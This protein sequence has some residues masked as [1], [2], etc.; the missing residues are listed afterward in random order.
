MS[1]KYYLPS[2]VTPYLRRILAEYKRDGKSKLVEIVSSS[3]IY[4]N[5]SIS[6]TNWDGGQDGHGVTLFLP[7]SVLHSIPIRSQKQYTDKLLEDLRT[8]AEQ[9]SGEYFSKVS[10]EAVDETDIHCQQAVHLTE[11]P[12]IDPDALTIWDKGC[13][14]L[15]ISHRDTHKAQAR[16]LAD[17]LQSYGI[18]A[19]VAHETIG[20][21]EKWQKVILDGLDTMEIMLAFITDD[22]QDSVWT[23][24][25]IGYALARN[26]PIL[27]LKLGTKDPAGFISDTQALKGKLDK[28]QGA[29]PEIY[30][31]LAEKLGNQSRLQAGL[32]DAFVHSP[33]FNAT[34][35]RFDR[36]KAHVTKLTDDELNKIIAAYETNDQLYKA[37]YLNN[38]YNRLLGFLKSTTGHTLS[39]DGNIIK[40]PFEDIPF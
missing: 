25:E 22:F 23:N 37:V 36:L 9:I 8:C 1:S 38:H 28:I 15:F 26:I 4:V 30:T 29:V 17:A 12:L 13:I 20:A 18:S 6:Y 24:Q 40:N 27:S 5:E 39:M 34:K 2:K 33:D 35:S 19:F 10:F 21:M 14:R 7:E 32:V 16:E 3:R 31:L 11:K